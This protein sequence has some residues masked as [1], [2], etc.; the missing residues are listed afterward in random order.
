MF[1]EVMVK[2]HSITLISKRVE[3]MPH[4]RNVFQTLLFSQHFLNP[5]S[6]IFSTG[7]GDLMF[8]IKGI[9]LFKPYLSAR[10]DEHVMVLY[11]GASP[12]RDFFFPA[13]F[14]KRPANER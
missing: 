11:T 5:L 6:M 13:H 10:I 7:S 3:L 1:Y 14:K 2:L 12:V 8:H 4:T 9:I